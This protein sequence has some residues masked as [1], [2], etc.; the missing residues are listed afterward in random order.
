MISVE[1][2]LATK[3]SDNIT[4]SDNAVVDEIKLPRA[5]RKRVAV[6]SGD[7][8]KP[9]YILPGEKWDQDDFAEFEKLK[10]TLK[11]LENE[12]EFVFLNNHETLIQDLIRLSKDID[13]VFQVKKVS[14]MFIAL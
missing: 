5:P 10:K 6:V 14:Q 4:V 1:E 13:L 12:Y 7:P 8:R 9:N 11:Q 2:Q 3:I